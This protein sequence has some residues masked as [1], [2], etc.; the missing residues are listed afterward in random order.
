MLFA[1]G[2]HG[3]FFAFIK[4]ADKWLKADSFFCGRLFFFAL[5][6]QI[7]CTAQDEGSKDELYAYIVQGFK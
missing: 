7:P 6:S 3:H 2:S 1:L 5:S 4:R